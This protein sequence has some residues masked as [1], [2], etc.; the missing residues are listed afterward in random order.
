M[1]FLFGASCQPW[2]LI[3][4]VMWLNLIAIY[5]SKCCTLFDSV[6]EHKRPNSS[7]WSDCWVC[8]WRT[9][10]ACRFP[11]PMFYWRWL[12]CW[13]HRWAP[14]S[15]TDP[16]RFA[17]ANYRFDCR[18][19]TIRCS[20][21]F[22]SRLFRKS[23]AVE[24]TAT[25]AA[26]V[27]QVLAISAEP[28]CVGNLR[29]RLMT[30]ICCKT[31]RRR[32]PRVYESPY[33]LTAL[34]YRKPMFVLLRL[35]PP[36]A[37]S[38]SAFHATRDF[39]D[40]QIAAKVVAQIAPYDAP[41]SDAMSGIRFCRCNGIS[42]PYGRSSV[43]PTGLSMASV[44]GRKRGV[45]WRTSTNVCT[46]SRCEV[47][48]Q[49]CVPVR[50]PGHRLLPPPV[51]AS[52]SWNPVCQFSARKKAR[53]SEFPRTPECRSVSIPD[54]IRSRLCPT[55]YAYPPRT[56]LA[57]S[58]C[59][60]SLSRLGLA[61]VLEAFCIHRGCCPPY[62]RTDWARNGIR[63]RSRACVLTGHS[64]QVQLLNLYRKKVVKNS[65][66]CKITHIVKT[67]HR[68]HRLSDRALPVGP[69]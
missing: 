26:H 7:A 43:D 49:T 9:F 11:A 48:R 21:S 20:G 23:L 40:V 69:W 25:L 6:A 5:L 46:L 24:G 22:W 58:P 33:L 56:C 59:W 44:G 35:L 65:L 18:Q 42:S 10:S 3:N 47:G 52:F 30:P 2:N 62:P 19:L 16:W 34:K 31:M 60:D 55:P 14:H 13:W 61:W 67:K 63:I 51:S 36:A 57:I 27:A 38:V 54:D 15:A 4:I 29:L 64:R 39:V 12:W 8:H 1:Q 28:A 37:E 41:D 32:S 45:R 68:V 66:R 50:V 17:W 53:F